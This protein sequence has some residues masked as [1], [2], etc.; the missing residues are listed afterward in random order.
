[1][2]TLQEYL[3]MIQ[4]LR[5]YPNAPYKPCLLLAI[6]QLVEQGDIL[7]NRIRLSNRLKD[8]FARYVAQIPGWNPKNIHNPFYHLKNDGFWHLSANVDPTRQLNSLIGSSRSPSSRQLHELVDYGYFDEP[9]FILVT[10][11]NNREIIRQAIL[12]RYFPDNREEIEYLIAEEHQIGEHRQLL[13]QEAAEHPFLYPPFVEPSED[14][15][16]RRQAFRQE[17]MRIYNY[18]CVI[19]RLRVATMDGESVTV[20]DAAHIV[21]FRISHSDD[22]RNGISL[23]K[24]HHWVF[25]RGLIS[26]NERYKIKVSR[27]I[28]EEG[29]VEWRLSNLHDK[30]ILLPRHEMLYPAQ[31]ALAWHRDKVFRQ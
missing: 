26:L 23:C 7:E 31:E 14:N 9:L 27:S 8:A 22:I 20:T 29:P 28:D 10:Q 16:V 21:P 5:R 4:N 15:P 3:E 19:C 1:M 6:I 25:D 13:I 2:S 11:P 30:D 12:E 18:T 17:I 24:L